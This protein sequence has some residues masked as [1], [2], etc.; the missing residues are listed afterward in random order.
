MLLYDIH[1]W[2]SLREKVDP[3]T[4]KWTLMREQHTMNLSIGEP[5]SLRARTLTLEWATFNQNFPILIGNDFALVSAILDPSE[6]SS[7]VDQ[8][9]ERYSLSS[10]REAMLDRFKTFF[11]LLFCRLV[12]V[13]GCFNCVWLCEC[14]INMSMWIRFKTDF[15]EVASVTIITCNRSCLSR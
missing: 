1:V 9:I 6:F 14:E 13:I 7:P 4:W 10:S 8:S 12:C 2:H 3:F 5:N 11:L 15:G